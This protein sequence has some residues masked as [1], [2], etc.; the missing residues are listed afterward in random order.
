MSSPRAEDGKLPGRL[1]LIRAVRALQKVGKTR[2]R[3]AALI[4]GTVLRKWSQD[5]FP[6]L[7]A[8]RLPWSNALLGDPAIL[9]FESHLKRL[10]LQDAAYWLSTAYTALSPPDYRKRLAMYF[11]PPSIANRLLD[12][13]ADEGT[14]FDQHSYMDPACGGAAFLALVAERM[15]SA[16][17]KKNKTPAAIL[18]H[19]NGHLAGI[20]VDRTLCALARHFLRMV[21]YAEIC[22]VNWAPRFDIKVGDSLTKSHRV[23]HQYD[24]V[25]CNPPYRKLSRKEADVHRAKF[26]EAMQGQPNLYALFIQLCTKLAKVNGVVGLLTPT[27]FLSGQSF[28]SIRSFLL[29]HAAVKH[30]GIIRDRLRVYFDVEQDTALTIIRPGKSVRHEGAIAGISV[31]DRSGQ[32][33]KVGNCR[34]PNSGSSWPL[35]REAADIALLKTAARSSFRLADY[36]YTPTI[37]AFVWNRDKRPTYSTYDKVP[38]SRRGETYPLLWASDLQVSGNLSFDQHKSSDSQHRYVYLGESGLT[39]VK[40]K[41]AVLLQRVTASDQEQRLVGATVSQ[42]FVSDHR[43]YVGENHVVILE[44][45]STT[46][47]LAPKQM[48][49]LLKTAVVNRY[50]NCISGCANVS[51]FELLQLP[52]PNPQDLKKLV[53]G[54]YS[55]EQAAEKILLRPSVSRS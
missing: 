45:S 47:A 10:P 41:P 6:K 2:G 19:A 26:A 3:T 49:A 24:V 29:N 42:Q 18:R 55:I 34:L 43:G 54:G 37:G 23:E 20:D 1:A 8:A 4:V 36:G 21:F 33:A 28:S 50:F 17:L 32:Y 40:K 22:S 46:P 12:D 48:L 51:V 5:S 13:L 35:A 9:A 44:Q 53:S 11:T 7:R 52:L 31:I 38:I 15:R 30:I 27:S 16:L 25:V 14:L 39:I